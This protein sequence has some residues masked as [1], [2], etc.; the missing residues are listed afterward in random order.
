[1]SSIPS[2]SGGHEVDPSLVRWTHVIYG[3]HAIAV[4]IGVTSAAAT[5]TDRKTM[6]GALILARRHLANSSHRR[7]CLSSPAARMPPM[8]QAR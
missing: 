7:Q 6:F 1:M 8:W 2:L 4:V 3:L 5:V